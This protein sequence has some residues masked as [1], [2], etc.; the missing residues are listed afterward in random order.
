MGHRLSNPSVT[1][2]GYVGRAEDPLKEFASA[3]DY[4]VH[5]MLHVFL[6]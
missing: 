3:V 2:A 6:H 4:V 5:V 1:Y